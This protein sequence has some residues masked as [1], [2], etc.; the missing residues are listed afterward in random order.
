M[1]CPN[2]SE[3]WPDE[4]KVCPMCTVS[5]SAELGEGASGAIAQAGSVAA[6]ARGVA[7]G[8]D[9]HGNVYVGPPPENFAEALHIYCRVLVQTS[10]RLPL[11]GVD[12]DASDPAGGRQH[13]GLAQVYVDLD[14]KTQL[15]LTEE[16]KRQRSERLLP[17]ERETRP[18]GALE[19]NIENRRLV[20][21]GDPGSG[22]STFQNHLAL[23]LAAHS[24]E[25]QAGWLSHISGWPKQ[26][27]DATDEAVIGAVRNL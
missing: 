26:E 5:L 9:V 10:G 12:L 16:E 2:C 24:L 23:C 4:F 27:E 25:P 7:V 11:R 8:G 3:V 1:Q 21:L 22:K 14:T 13:L 15:P 18:V 17:E 20:L 19:A 6:G